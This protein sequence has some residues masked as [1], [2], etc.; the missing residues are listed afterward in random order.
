M[1]RIHILGSSG[2][3]KSTLAQ[4]LSEQLGAPHIQLDALNFGPNWTARP[5]DELRQ[6][7]TDAVAGERWIIDGNYCNLWEITLPRATTVIWLNYSF[8]LVFNRVLR[9]TFRRSLKRERLFSENRE[10]LRKAFFSRDSILWWVI[11][12]FRGRRR[13]ARELFEDVRYN[14]LELI[15]HRHPRE[16]ARFLKSRGGD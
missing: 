3:G 13:Q 10:T 16:T 9:R 15:E 8:P 14:H 4:N 6:S 12:S 1:Q 5:H 11:T 7:V 2:A